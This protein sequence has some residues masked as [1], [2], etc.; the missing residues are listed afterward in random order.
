[1][2]NRGW[3]YLVY[4]WTTGLCCSKVSIPDRSSEPGNSDDMAKTFE[5]RPDGIEKMGM[6]YLV[7]KLEIMISFLRSPDNSKTE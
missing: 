1:M 2:S 6:G 4:T 7:A 3:I 5:R